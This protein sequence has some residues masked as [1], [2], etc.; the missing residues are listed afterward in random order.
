MKQLL[1]LCLCFC[2]LTQVFAQNRTYQP[3]K[4]D[5]ATGFLF[6]TGNTFMVSRLLFSPEPK[7]NVTDQFSLGLRIELVPNT[8]FGG[9][10][11]SLYM[12]N[13][14]SYVFTGEYLFNNTNNVRP[15]LGVGA[16]I[17]SQ[18][19]STTVYPVTTT[20]SKKPGIATR[21]GV[22]WRHFRFAVEYNLTFFEQEKKINYIGLK[23]G[24]FLWGNYKCK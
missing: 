11:D 24:G 14:F 1:F 2:P 3:F 12:D 10:R 19:L 18:T 21:A 13:M 20:K 15:L 9:T 17:F 7:F 4:L 5:L 22:E 16:G 23:F 6:P 8:S